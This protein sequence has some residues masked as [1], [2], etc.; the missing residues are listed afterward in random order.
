MSTIQLMKDVRQGEALSA[1]LAT[2]SVDP[3]GVCRGTIAGVTG[4]GKTKV[5]IEAIMKFFKTGE[6]DTWLNTYG[7]KPIILSVPTE[8]LRDVT[9][10]DEI[11]KFYGEDGLKLFKKYVLPVCYASLNK[12]KCNGLLFIGDEIHNMTEN[13]TKEFNNG[14][15]VNHIIGL[16]ATPPDPNRDATKAA[17]IESLAPVVYTYTYED[18][19]RDGVISDFEVYIVS[20]PLD[21]TRKYIEAGKKDNRFFTTESAAYAFADKQ[22]KKAYSMPPGKA[23][24]AMFKFATLSRMQLIYKMESKLEVAGRLISHYHVKDA[25]KRSLIFDATIDRLQKLMPAELTYH[26]KSKNDTALKKFMDKS[27]R[28]L[29][30]VQALNEGV[31]TPDVDYEFILQVNSNSRHTVQRI[32]RSIRFKEGHKTRVFILE[33]QGTQDVNW[34]MEAIKDIPPQLVFRKTLKELLV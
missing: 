14:F 32:G 19:L 12:L 18:A 1:W 3:T 17:I 13:N 6:L 22:L 34:V 28:V 27:S 20:V 9:W 8:E 21:Y 24:E 4:F 29:G 31:N 26:S 5:A 10:A 11:K 2:G 30:A 16:S 23:K 15:F 7:Q 25:E 33:Q